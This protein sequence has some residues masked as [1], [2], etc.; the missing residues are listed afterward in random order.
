MMD[1]ETR[2]RFWKKVSLDPDPASCWEWKAG[3]GGTGYG[4]FWLDGKMQYAHRVAW[5]LINGSIPKGEGYHGTCV[6]HECDNRVCVRPDHLFLGSNA[7]NIRDKVK[8]GR[9][10]RTR[11]EAQGNAK[12]TSADVYAIR[13]DPR[14]QCE[15]AADYG[16][17]QAQVSRIKRRKKWAHLPEEESRHDQL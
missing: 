15:I 6:L 2:N 17:G 14:T 11:G 16:V 4:Q 8:K 9:Q 12:L 3:Q 10:S 13:S 5:T 7:D 1:R